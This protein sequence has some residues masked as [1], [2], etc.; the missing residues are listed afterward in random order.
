M[1]ILSDIKTSI[2]KFN[3]AELTSNST[4]KTSSSGTMGCLICTIGSIAFL[5]ASISKNSEL[6]NQSV[7]FTSLG[8]GL[9]GL[10]KANEKYEQ[11]PTTDDTTPTD[12]TSTEE[13]PVK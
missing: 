7:I 12:D 9:L 2:S 10:K 8:A 3:F 13:D 1:K 6:I 5:I 11:I 4:G